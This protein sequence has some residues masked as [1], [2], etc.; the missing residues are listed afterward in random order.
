MSDA[1]SVL[2]TG[3]SSGI[4]LCL[5]E[6]LKANNYQVFASARQQRDVDQLNERGFDSIQLDLADAMS[7]KNAVLKVRDKTNNRLYALINNGAYGQPGA[8]EDISRDV[9]KE[10]FE[11]NVFGTHELTNMVL[12]IMRQQGEGRIIQISSIL[13]LVCFAYRGPYNA[14]KYA[15]EALTDT[16]RLE[17]RDTNIFCS[18]IEPGPIKSKF[19]ANAFAAFNKN[20]DTENSAHKKKYKRL[21]ARLSAQT[22]PTPFTAEPEAVL[23]RVVQ[24]LEARKPRVRY[25]VTFPV[26]LFEVL[27][28]LL[29]YRALDFILDQAGD[30]RIKRN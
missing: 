25:P 16:L 19:R 15:L 5:A 21:I 10:Q 26:Y 7:I 13:G 12:P 3:C 9:L 4:G 2:I 17:L 30:G 24:A 27:R 1:K 20:I 14:T 11:T 29:P 8:L 28:R 22:A 23:K 6:G 18:L